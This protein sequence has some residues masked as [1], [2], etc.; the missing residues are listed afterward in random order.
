MNRAHLRERMDFSKTLH[1][2]GINTTHKLAGR[3]RPQN[4]EFHGVAMAT[5][6]P[7]GCDALAQVGFRAGRSRVEPGYFRNPVLNRQRSHCDSRT[8]SLTRD[9]Q[10]SSSP[11]KS[12]QFAHNLR[13]RARESS[14]HAHQ[15]EHAR[16]NLLFGPEFLLLFGK[17]SEKE[18]HH[19]QIDRT[20]KQTFGIEIGDG[21]FDDLQVM[22]SKPNP[23]C[24]NAEYEAA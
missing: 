15:A 11:V 17:I 13:Q 12:Q 4:S 20:H 24:S 14:V 7:R 22:V 5:G 21:Y 6:I 2:G 1:W 16:S 19:E 3:I 18:A 8:G 10:R 23:R 9:N